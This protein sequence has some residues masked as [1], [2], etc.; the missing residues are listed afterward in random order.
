MA[1]QRIPSF[2]DYL[3]QGIENYTDS[4]ERRQ[5]R[6]MRARQAKLSE[7]SF[8]SSLYGQGALPS[9]SLQEQ[10][11]SSGLGLPPVT[12]Q[13]SAAERRTQILNRPDVNV[14]VPGA[15]IGTRVKIK[16]SDTATDDER[17]AAGLPSMQER[18]KSAID[19]KKGQAEL[20]TVERT[21]KDKQLEDAAPRF[22]SGVMGKMGPAA[23]SNPEAAAEAAFGEYKAMLSKSKFGGLPPADEPYARAFFSKAVRDAIMEERKLEVQE[24]IAA[25]RATAQDFR[26]RQLVTLRESARKELDDMES[27]SRFGQ[28]VALYKGQPLE[29]VPV[30]FRGLMQ[31]HMERENYIRQIDDQLDRLEPTGIKRPTTKVEQAA[32]QLPSKVATA[33]EL[34]KQGKATLDQLKAAVGKT[35]TK[36]EVQQV[37]EALK[38]KGGTGKTF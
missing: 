8:L 12:V 1:I 18:V 29:Q 14:E 7:L 5:D 17:V 19:I 34:I 24:R 20:G 4:R 11:N 6:E 26:F 27:N 23:R 10:I 16:G 36:E 30:S 22:V 31:A 21:T 38:S 25:N 37:E 33:I 2:F 28:I 3:G 13:P 9:G 15:P 35:F 32:G